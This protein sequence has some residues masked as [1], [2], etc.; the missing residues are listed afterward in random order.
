MVVFYVG[1]PGRR[2]KKSFNANCSSLSE[3]GGKYSHSSV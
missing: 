1:L 3:M 2:I